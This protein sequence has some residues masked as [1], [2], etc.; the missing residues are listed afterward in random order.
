M[1]ITQKVAQEGTVECKTVSLCGSQVG[2]LCCD[3]MGSWSVLLS[4]QILHCPGAQME[5]ELLFSVLVPFC[6]AAL[7]ETILSV[8][9][10][11]LPHWLCLGNSDVTSRHSECSMSHC[12]SVSVGSLTPW[13]NQNHFRPLAH[14]KTQFW[15]LTCADR[16]TGMKYSFK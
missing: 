8:L 4:H 15:C 10:C 7:P 11:F 13:K 3:G 1:V 12:S 6:F 16:F 14:P 9:L 5:S 2:H